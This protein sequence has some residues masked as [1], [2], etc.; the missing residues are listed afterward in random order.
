MKDPFFLGFLISAFG[1]F[2][3]LI[4]VICFAV[5]KKKFAGNKI[6][7]VLFLYLF[8][9]FLIELFCNIIGFLKPNSNIF[10]SHYAFNVQ[11]LFL[12]IFFYLLFKQTALKKMV[13]AIFFIFIIIN[14]CFYFNEPNLY[15]KFNLF[16]IVSISFITLVFTL[17]HLYNN[18]GEE[19]N[20][21]YFTIGVSMY[22]LS[23]SIVFLLGNFELV[24][25]KDPFIDIWVFNSLFFIV[26]QVLIFKEWK[27]LN[28]TNN[29][30]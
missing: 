7:N 12:S 10:V 16:E 17:I 23:T 6:Y 27:Y 18:L 20:Y 29:N 21:F 26:Y 24:F 8:F 28:F 14:S 1:L 22:M 3:L 30:E 19:K 11:F 9:Y 13:V 25:C 2:L 4:N 15:W 5:T